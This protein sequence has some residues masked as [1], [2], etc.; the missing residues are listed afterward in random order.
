MGKLEE[1]K[2]VRLK[3]CVE[4]EIKKD[5][6]K[7]SHSEWEIELMKNLKEVC[8]WEPWDPWSSNA[9]T[10]GTT[11][12]RRQR[13]CMCG[14][15]LGYG[16]GC[17]KGDH[18]ELRHV[19]LIPC[20]KEK[21]DVKSCQ[22]QQWSSWSGKNKECGVIRLTKRRSCKCEGREEESD[23]CRGDPVIKRTIFKPCEDEIENESSE[24][25]KYM[26]DESRSREDS[27]PKEHN[28]Y[29]LVPDE[30]KAESSESHEDEGPKPYGYSTPKP[31]HTTPPP[32]KK[33]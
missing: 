21:D 9:K 12:Q 14:E 26:S 32:W 19:D 1:T 7:K 25:K 2:L 8:H 33:I 10:C 31:Y 11:I 23:V 20:K 6:K 22:W 15:E 13:P 29:D 18:Q 17:F 4:K 16:A 3:A 30:F 28:D 27:A 24:G 5:P